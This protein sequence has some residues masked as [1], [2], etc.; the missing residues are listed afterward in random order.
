VRVTS[1]WRP[2]QSVHMGGRWR[3]VLV[4]AL[5]LSAIAVGGVSALAAR[6]P[7][8]L[9]CRADREP[10]IAS[11]QSH[12]MPLGLSMDMVLPP[13]GDADC[14]VLRQ[15]LQASASVA[16]RYPTLL[17]PLAARFHPV[18]FYIPGMG[19]HMESPRGIDAEFNPYEPEYLLYDGMS[20]ASRL[21][22]LSYAAADPDKGIP[23][24][25][26]GNHDVPHSHAYCPRQWGWSGDR[27]PGE[28]GCTRDNAKEGNTW[29][30]HVW[31]VPGHP[32]PWGVFS[33]LNPNITMHG[34]D[35]MHPM[36]VPQLS[37]LYGT[38][39]ARNA[40]AIR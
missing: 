14:R 10:H 34:W 30:I 40:C 31:I 17:S 13:L 15:Q 32:S 39:S 28:P 29:M 25:F 38:R 19:L 3:L 36:T 37:C 35:S 27:S 4:C 20:Y 11:S 5:G 12:Q 9:L 6:G 18:G 16:R 8:P 7:V 21:V 1:E 2:V 26:A 23:D 22:G 24:F 33:S